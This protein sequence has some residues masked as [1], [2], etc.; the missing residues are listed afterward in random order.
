MFVHAKS[1]W[2]RN[3]QLKVGAHFFV[4]C[5]RRLEQRGRR[6]TIFVGFSVFVGYPAAAL[7][8]SM[9][10]VGGMRSRW[11]HFVRYTRRSTTTAVAT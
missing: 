3:L 10:L 4:E 1:N 8:N 2:K 5:W 11:L 6:A 9:Y 7:T